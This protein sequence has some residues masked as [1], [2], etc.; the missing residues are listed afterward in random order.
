MT[1]PN[2]RSAMLAALIAVAMTPPLEAVEVTAIEADSLACEALREN[3]EQNDARGRVRCVEA[4]ASS[5]DLARMGPVSGVVANIESGPLTALMDGFAAALEPG[6]W[7]VLSGI[8]DHEWP[9]IRQRA[10]SAGFRL[11]TLDAEGEWRSALLT[12]SASSASLLSVISTTKPTARCAAPV[13]VP[14]RQAA[15]RTQRISPFGRM[16]RKVI[17]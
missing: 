2:L 3:V 4:M 6:G 9:S 12:R 11:E 7:L 8:L 14:V 17:E 16:M 15:E 13:A 10:E 5:A 1:I